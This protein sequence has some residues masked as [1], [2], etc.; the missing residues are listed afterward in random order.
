MPRPPQLNQHQQ[1]ERQL[2][3]DHKESFD[4]ISSAGGPSERELLDLSHEVNAAWYNLGIRL[5]FSF[6]TLENIKSNAGLGSPQQ[7]ALEMFV[8]WSH[9]METFSYQALWQALRE[10]GY[11]D[12]AKKYCGH[13]EVNGIFDFPLQNFGFG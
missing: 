6:H 8:Q 2:Y 1:E 3:F 5:G 10:E 13:V 9:G 12:L 7:K 4:I 11:C